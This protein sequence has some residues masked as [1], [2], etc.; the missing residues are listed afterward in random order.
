MKA[1]K[2]TLFIRGY[3]AIHLCN[4]IMVHQLFTQQHLLGCDIQKDTIS[5]AFSFR[6]KSNSVVSRLD[7]RPGFSACA[8]L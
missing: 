5:R 4:T 1:T 8:L 2:Q 6:L 3:R 7:A